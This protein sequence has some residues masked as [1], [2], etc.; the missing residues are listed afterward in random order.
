MAERSRKLGCTRRVLVPASLHP[1]YRKTMA[2]ILN[3]QNIAIDEIPC[4]D[5]VLTI[6]ALDR[7]TDEFTALMISQPNFF[8]LI[9][10][11][12]A[13]TNWAHARGALAIAVVKPVALGLLKAQGQCGAQCA[14][15]TG[16]ASG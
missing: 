5:G 11:V 14:D 3:L 7:V 12:D 2:T 6:D 9:E 16:R 1:A 15:K 4:P 13:L 10:D 8:G